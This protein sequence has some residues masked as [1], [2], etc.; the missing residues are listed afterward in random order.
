MPET[1]HNHP[2]SIKEDPTIRTAPTVPTPVSKDDVVTGKS[3][4][5]TDKKPEEATGRK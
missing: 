4:C 2:F 3:A 5:V 1:P